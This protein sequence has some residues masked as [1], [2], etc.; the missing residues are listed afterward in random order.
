RP[1]REQQSVDPTIWEK[2]SIVWYSQ[3][4]TRKLGKE[5][6]AE[7]VRDFG[8]GNADVQGVPGYTDGLTESWLMSSLKI[9]G[10]QQADF[11]HRFLTGKLPAS[12]AAYDNTKAIIPQFTAAD[13]WQV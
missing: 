2:D 3:E 9:S 10:D 8:Y 4:I 12:K 7:Y 5:K 6:F 1:K 13:G 11:M